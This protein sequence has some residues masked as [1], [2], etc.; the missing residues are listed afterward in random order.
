MEK[1][2]PPIVVVFGHPGSGK[3]TQAKNLVK[4]FSF[5]YMETGE[6]FRQEMREN[7]KFGKAITPYMDSGRLVPSVLVHGIVQATILKNRDE[8]TKKGAVFDG[9]PRKPADVR[10]MWKILRKAKITNPV[11][12]INLVTSD[13]RLRK[14]LLS[15]GREDD[16]PKLIEK[17]F[18]EYH[19]VTA[20]ALP[21]LRAKTA[22][23]DIDGNPPIPIVAQSIEKALKPYIL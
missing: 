14:R 6:R 21:L 10:A 8:I 23:L 13:D 16:K 3:G 11:L 18:K 1:I 20:P 9:F 7:S 12:V 19:R 22:V 15:R 4:R 5:F 17:R 2:V